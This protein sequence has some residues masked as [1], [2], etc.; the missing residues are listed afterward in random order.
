MSEFL[1]SLLAINNKHDD[2]F[3]HMLSDSIDRVNKS[4]QDSTSTP[5]NDAYGNSLTAVGTDDKVEKFD[6][7]QFSNDTLNWMLWLA[8]YNDSWVFKRAIDKPAQDQVRAGITIQGDE[9]YENVYR[10]LKKHRSDFIELISWGALFGGSI[11]CLMFDNLKDDDYAKPMDIAK[12]K[13]SKTMKMYVVDR[14]YGVQPSESTVTNMND[15]DFGKPS[16]YWVTL[17]NG[18]RVKF[19]HSY[20][21]RYEHRVAPKLVKYGMLQGWGYAEGSHIFNELSRDDKLK[22]DIQ[23]LVSKCLIEII[24][25]SGMRGVFMGADADNEAQLTKRLEMVNWGRSFNSLTFLDKD[26]EYEQAQFSGLEGL[27]SLLE[28]NMALIASALDMSG[29]LFGP[30]TNGFS[31][32]DDALERYDN[33]IRERCEAHVRPIYEKFLNIVCKIQGINEH[34]EFE[35][36]SLLSEKQDK[37]TLES[38]KSF[39]EL[40]TQLLDSGVIELKQFARAI[41]TYSKKHIIDFGLTD[42]VIEKLEDKMQEELEDININEEV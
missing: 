14:W 38:L 16:Y 18:H 3:E 2:E 36:N 40:G 31:N 33:T 17:S 22:S 8:L 7:Y 21:L 5:I 24:K 35:F 39:V 25:M 1:Q 28:K 23:S 19:H 10:V 32:D 41:Q 20:V 13:K 29:V 6:N 4:I 34:L 12:L 11:A 15:I 26:D 37:E 42:D 9:N 30:M 27:S